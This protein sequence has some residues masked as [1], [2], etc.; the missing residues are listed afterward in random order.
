MKTTDRFETMLQIEKTCKEIDDARRA[1]HEE[2]KKLYSD[3]TKMLDKMRMD[4][5][6]ELLNAKQLGEYYKWKESNE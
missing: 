2:F 5:T 1:H 6:T 3:E 4:L